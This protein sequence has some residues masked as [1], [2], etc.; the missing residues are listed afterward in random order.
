[1]TASPEPPPN[2]LQLLQQGRALFAIARAVLRDVDGAEDA[3]QDALMTAL[4]RTGGQHDGWLTRIVQNFAR[5]RLR[6]L[7]RRRQR[8]AGLP[9]PEP[10]PA[11]DAVAAQIETHRLVAVAMQQV[12][13]PYRSTLV[14][15]FWHDLPPRAIARRLGIPV[16]TVKSRLQR[17]LGELR[18]RLDAT[19][20]DRRQWIVALAPFA[21]PAVGATA[22][23]G[24]NL[25]FAALLPLALTTMKTLL[26]LFG[27]GIGL[28]LWPWLTA[29]P[30]A[31]VRPDEP[32]TTRIVATS[33]SDEQQQ[34]D[35]A[36]T[37]AG[38]AAP[39]PR[40]SAD[41]PPRCTVVGRILG[42][43]GLPIA[44]AQLR[45]AHREPRSLIAEVTA[46]TADDGTFAVD[47][48]RHQDRLPFSFALAAAPGWAVREVQLY[49]G[50]A[51]TVRDGRVDLGT[52]TLERGVAVAGRIVE[53]DGA[54]LRQR[55][56]LL[57]V[58]PARQGSWSLMDGGR[59]VGHA[60]SGGEFAL[61]ERLAAGRT[62]KLVLVAVGASGLGWLDLEFA[63]G[64]T[65]LP[66]QTLSLLAGDAVRLR[67]V[68]E[69]GQP[70]AGATVQ[71][72]PHFL[73]I[74]LA[75]MWRDS[76]QAYVA[77]TPENLA[78]LHR[79][80]DTDGTVRFAALPRIDDARIREANREHR[81]SGM[82]VTVEREGFVTNSLDVLPG[83]DGEVVVTLLRPR[84]FDLRATVLTRA[85]RPLRGISIRGVSF[86]ARRDST[87]DDD[88]RCLIEAVPTGEAWLELRGET[89]P[90]QVLAVNHDGEGVVERTFVVDERSAVT[91][92][93]VDDLGAPVAAVEVLLGVQS[94]TYY[95]S[96]PERTAA[97]GAFSF[98]DATTEHN[99]L[100]ITPPKPWTRWR[101]P[102]DL[103]LRQR[104]GVVIV[105]ARV[106]SPLLDLRLELV[107]GSSQS[108]VSPTEVELM[109]KSG[110]WSVL[111][112]EP[113]LAHG[114]ASFAAIPSGRYRALV[115]AEGGRCCVHDFEVPVSGTQH[116]ERVML[117]PTG[118]VVCT[119][120]TSALPAEALARMQGQGILLHLEGEG[121]RAQINALDANGRPRQLTENTGL[122]IVG[123]AMTFRLDGV[124]ALTPRR[125]VVLHETLFGEAWFTASPGTETEVTLRLVPFGTLT[126]E[127]PASWPA[128]WFELDLADG[129]TWHTAL[130]EKFAAPGP[131]AARQFPVRTATGERRWRMRFW[132]ATGGESRSA[133]GTITIRSGEAAT[134]R[135]Q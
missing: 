73:P 56:R 41:A 9:T 68:G 97:D 48:P 103:T 11:T 51:S 131:D 85:G 60:E 58:D 16:A 13:E 1:M 15:R 95:P 108:P 99:Q 36:H 77:R 35:Q 6:D 94:G 64:Q 127:V 134:V 128:G 107:D 59:T 129:D 46:P 135:P 125:L 75:P 123:G 119:V 118:S 42:D 102:T 30:G 4:R 50:D 80:S 92:R 96:Q 133:D 84:T 82:L 130:E 25:T 37:N 45:L 18:Q 24:T 38:S 2:E 22:V 110:E 8:H 90:R 113:T 53:A 65:T 49:H 17:G 67:I 89:V 34:R 98:P 43:D 52:L 7:V 20:G 86:D 47:A 87:T 31:P 126:V 76:H 63:A 83:H 93:V 40:E 54:P 19:S 112:V 104:E 39:L 101:L 105:L 88:G 61:A 27:I 91:G 78:L 28:L 124:T 69:D 66:R 81:P 3:V 44:N 10:A 33:P 109:P 121:E 23:A 62:G 117:W 111:S 21:V 120:D 26:L 74:G 132:P 122:V 100:R 29:R 55:A 14:L 72:T 115:R 12:G 106:R 57:V 5:R 116:N 114:S 71:T 70:I 79:V 32:A